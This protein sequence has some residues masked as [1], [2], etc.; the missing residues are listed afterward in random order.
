[1]PG[2]QE[3]ARMVKNLVV[4]RVVALEVAPTYILREYVGVPRGDSARAS[5]AGITLARILFNFPSFT[6]ASVI[7]VA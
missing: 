2:H 7:C 1:M 3:F 5:D 6:A 4:R